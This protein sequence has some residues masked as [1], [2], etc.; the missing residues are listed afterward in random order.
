[1]GEDKVQEGYLDLLQEIRDSREE[2]LED[3]QKLEDLI[4]ASN[5]LFK[6]IKTSSELKL[7]ARINAISTRMSCSRME[8]DIESDAFTSMRLVELIENDML[9]DFYRY[10][11]SCNREMRFLDHISFSQKEN[12][13][14]QRAATQRAK[15]VPADAETPSSNAKAD[16]PDD[17]A[18]ILLQ[19][20]DVLVE[21]MEYFSFVVDPE[22]FSRTVENVFYL[23]LAVRSG[24]LSLLCDGNV[25]YVT[26]D[27]QSG[28]NSEHFSLELSYDEYVEIVQRMGI[29][30]GLIKR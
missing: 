11:M 23:S 30:K 3:K 10:A 24:A 18:R 1:M 7:D 16:D 4:D 25:L 15:L 20:K 29:A 12:R 5:K 13:S 2:I 27:R 26:P 14:E 22:S 19:M 17:G 6:R 28:G 9:D 21:R 8:K